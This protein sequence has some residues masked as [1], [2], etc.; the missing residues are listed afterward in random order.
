MFLL[1][2]GPG[3]ADEAAPSL[4]GRYPGLQIVG[5]LCPP[6]RELTAEENAALIGEVREARPDFLIVAFTQPAGERWLA[7]NLEALGIPVMANFGAA[8]D[9]AAGRV[10][11]APRWMQSIGMEWAFRLWLE[12]RRLA[13]R[14]ARNARFIARMLFAPP[15]GRARGDDG[16]Q[17]RQCA[18][19]LAADPSSADA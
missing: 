5:T 10:R 19:P 17:G 1:G 12:P 15:S 13:G 18:T 9:F 8:I 7:N 2:G 3:V 4:V 14:C 6:F 11:R 16:L